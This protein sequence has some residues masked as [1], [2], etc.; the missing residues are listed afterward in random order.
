M[1][2]IEYCDCENCSSVYTDDD[3]WGHWDVCCTCN[4]PIEGTYVYYNHYDGEDHEE[5]WD[6]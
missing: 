1:K 3:E 5:G 2:K 6:L 4:K